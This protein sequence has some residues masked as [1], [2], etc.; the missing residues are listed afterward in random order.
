MNKIT[1]TI[2]INGNKLTREYTGDAYSLDTWGERVNDMLDTIEKSK[3][4][5][6]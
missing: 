6:F 1:I 2:D 3:E 4:V 5:K